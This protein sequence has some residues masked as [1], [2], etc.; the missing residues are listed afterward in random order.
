MKIHTPLSR[1]AFF[2]S[3]TALAAALAG[4]A[5]DRPK[6]DMIVRSVRP[7]DLE[8]PLDGFNSWITPIERFFVR[9][10]MSKPSVNLASWRLSIQVEV[11]SPLELT[12]DELKKLPAVE[13]VSV[14]ECAG[15]GRAF[16]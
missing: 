16:Y 10:H 11:S 1:R 4:R 5:A 3:A 2:R 6:R 13:V 15:N 14:L 7:E 12:M 9:Y 8:M